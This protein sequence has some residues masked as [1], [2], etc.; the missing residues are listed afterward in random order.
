MGPL[1]RLRSAGRLLEDVA[2]APLTTYKLGGPARYVVVVSGV[3]DLRDAYAHASQAALPV[4]ALGRGS[5]VVVSDAGFDGI[6]LRPGPELSRRSVGEVVVAGAGVPLPILARDTAKAGHGGLEFYTGIPGS[7][8]GAVRMNAGCHGSETSDVLIT[9]TVFDAVTGTAEE[10]SA[11]DLELRY[12]HSNLGDQHYV[13]EA[14]F[15]TYERDRADAEAD[16]RE[17]T[18]WRKQHQP[19]GTLNAGSVFKNPEGD[20]AG[21]LIDSVGL[22]G[23][24]VGGVSVS[25]RHANFFVAGRDA[26][27]AD[28]HVLVQEISRRVV[29]ATGVSLIPEVR[30]LGDFA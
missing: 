2:L 12:R 27:A 4:V 20:S 3:D 29:D 7:V 28:V 6:V 15:D 11:A 25:E 18:R 17:V 5:N 19:G 24:S 26:S 30:F 13:I 16:I 23:F 10:R 14:R 22:K 1:D 8:G 21:R 9:A